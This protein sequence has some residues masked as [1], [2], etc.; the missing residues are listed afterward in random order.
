MVGPVSPLTILTTVLSELARPTGSQCDERYEAV[1]VAWVFSFVRPRV[2]LLEAPRAV[3]VDSKHVY[4]GDD[5]LT[6]H[7]RLPHINTLNC[8]SRY[9]LSLN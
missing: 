8:C 7:D 6:L 9:E 2:I 5:W 3:L 4:N 1:W